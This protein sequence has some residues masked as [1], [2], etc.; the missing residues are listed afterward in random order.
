[1]DKFAKNVL[2]KSPGYRLWYRYRAQGGGRKDWPAAAPRSMYKLR[3]VCADRLG[4]NALRR[5][6]RAH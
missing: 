1:M 2:D 5:R 6:V 4:Q 3:T